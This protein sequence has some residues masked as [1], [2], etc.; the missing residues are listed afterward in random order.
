MMRIYSAVISLASV[1]LNACQPSQQDALR[2][3]MQHQRNGIAQTAEAVPEPQSFQHLPYEQGARKDPFASQSL[4]ER[5]NAQAQGAIPGWRMAP[6]SGVRDPLENIALEA[7]HFVG[8]L[9]KNGHGIGL[10]L[11]NGVVHP[12]SAGQYIG[13]NFAKVVRV[14]ESGIA[15]RE[16]V[17]DAGGKW[18]TRDLYLRLQGSGK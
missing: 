12:V 7:M 9:E 8:M 14:D 10:I 6:P 3:W 16:P 13:T 4:M 18:F 17:R 11:A 1:L 15:L 5:V 2:E